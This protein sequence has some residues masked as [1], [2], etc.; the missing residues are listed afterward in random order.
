MLPQSELERGMSASRQ[1]ALREATELE[2]IKVICWTEPEKVSL[3]RDCLLKAVLPILNNEADI[4]VP[5]RT[6]ASF[7]TY[8]DYQVK[9][10]QRSNRLWND[11]LRSR[12]LLPQESE[13]LD[14][15]FGPKFFGNDPELVEL[16]LKRYEFIKGKV[17]LHEIIKPEL[18]PNATFLPIVAAL[19]RGYRVMNVPVPYIHP[20]E[21]TEIEKDSSEFRR[22]RD[23]Q[24]KNIIVSTVH[25]IRMLENIPYKRSRLKLKS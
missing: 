20:A 6:D 19:H 8:P 2:G 15:W 9:Y 10:E 3:L 25:F 4:V 22:K 18:W 16:F 7:K 17:R 24:R 11:I 5:M 13:D 1:Q 21:Q 23:I 12:G 14:V